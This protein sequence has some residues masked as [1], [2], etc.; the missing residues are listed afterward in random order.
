MKNLKIKIFADGAD[1]AGMRAMAAR[2][3]IAGFTTNPSL[4]RKAG[5]TD[6][7]AFAK[8]VLAA[9]PDRPISFEVIADEFDDMQRQA[10]V[11]ASWGPNV[12]VKIPVTNTR[13]EPSYDL[14][15]RLS[16]GGVKVNVT[17]CLTLAQVGDV[18]RA[19]AAGS[20]SC[21]S[22]FAGRIADAGRDPVPLMAAA[23]EMLRPYPEQELIWAS[24]REV[25]N[26]LQADAVGCHVIT[27]TND[28]LAKLDLIGKDLTE[29][30]LDTVKMFYRDAQKAGLTVPEE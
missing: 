9:I 19:L 16:R 29:F 2:P 17:A 12:Y 4:M 7:A 25:L 21:I 8:Q 5:V 20:P 13:R 18:S 27:V 24:P 26:I 15:R 22:V 10:R 3:Y 6:Y 1:L 14:I 11:L 28:I 30:S 23:V